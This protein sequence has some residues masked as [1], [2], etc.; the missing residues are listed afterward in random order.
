MFSTSDTQSQ[1]NPLSSTLTLNLGAE[2]DVYVRTD[3]FSSNLPATGITT[4]IVFVD[5]EIV[6]CL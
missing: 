6:S 3:K 2:Y 5:F 4:S 1:I